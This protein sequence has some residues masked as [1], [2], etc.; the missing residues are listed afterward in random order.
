MRKKNLFMR[1]NETSPSVMW[2]QCYDFLSAYSRQ[3]KARY[4]KRMREKE[5]F[6][7]QEVAEMAADLHHRLD[8]ILARDEDSREEFPETK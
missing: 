4:I 7:S 6:T 3:M 5:A 8:A 1:N 2:A